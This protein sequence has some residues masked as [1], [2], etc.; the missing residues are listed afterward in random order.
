[1]ANDQE[2]DTT[3]HSM[4]VNVV[5]NY[6]VE[7]G[8]NGIAVPITDTAG[9]Q[10]TSGVPDVAHRS[11]YDRAQETEQNLLKMRDTKK[12]NLML[13]KMVKLNEASKGNLESVSGMSLEDVFNDYMFVHPTARIDLFSKE[14]APTQQHPIDGGNRT[15]D[16]CDAADPANMRN[17][18]FSKETNSQPIIIQLTVSMERLIVVMLQL[19]LS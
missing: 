13:G 15:V 4:Q 7:N 11:V 17:E 10:R 19:E 9:W 14:E 1:V 8:A 16:C 6:Y 5:N 18:L 3:K 12:R 2:N